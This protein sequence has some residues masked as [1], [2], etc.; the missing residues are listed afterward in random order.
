ML[1]RI[2]SYHKKARNIIIDWARKTSLEIVLLA[3]RLV[4][5]IAREDLA[6]HIEA[7]RKLPKD[8]K[9]KTNHYGIFK[10]W[11]MN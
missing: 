6:G 10:A 4:Y 2:R 9:I 8:H 1:G 7:L 3:K 11:K 5:A